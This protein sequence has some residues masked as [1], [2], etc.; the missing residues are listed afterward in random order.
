MDESAR[1]GKNNAIKEHGK[2]TRIRHA[3]MRPLC[4]ELKLDLKCL[5]KVEQEKLRH[6]FTQCRWLCNHL[7]SLDEDSVTVIDSTSIENVVDGV[8]IRTYDRDDSK[9]LAYARMD[10]VY[11]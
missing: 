3:S 4:V 2:E 1:I 9:I 8:S 10:L 7:I 5:N 11:E 6:Y